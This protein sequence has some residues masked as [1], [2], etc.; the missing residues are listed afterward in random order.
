MQRLSRQVAPTGWCRRDLRRL[1]DAHAW[2][3]RQFDRQMVPLLGNSV[4]HVLR[5]LDI[6]AKHVEV[7]GKCTDLLGFFVEFR[8]LCLKNCFLAPKD[9]HLAS[10]LEDLDLS[11]CQRVFAHLFL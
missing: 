6:V 7:G 8:E 1:D 9:G 11:F 2:G 10:E 3:G 5:L 4:E